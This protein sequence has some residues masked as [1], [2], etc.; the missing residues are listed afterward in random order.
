MDEHDL[1]QAEFNRKMFQSEQDKFEE[2][3]KA[4]G[5]KEAA[6]KAVVANAAREEAA[7]QQQMYEMEQAKLTE[8]KKIEEVRAAEEAVEKAKMEKIEQFKAIKEAQYHQERLRQ[9]ERDLVKNLARKKIEED[10]A[11]ERAVLDEDEDDDEDEQ[12]KRKECRKKLK[13][14]HKKVLQ[15]GKRGGVWEAVRTED[16]GMA[17]AYFMVQGTG[18]LLKMHNFTEG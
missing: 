10:I 16:V 9:E 5:D 12:E 15:N 13:I 18:N 8:L 6:A 3:R 17:R 14:Y 4:K 2:K 11:R 7:R 1:L